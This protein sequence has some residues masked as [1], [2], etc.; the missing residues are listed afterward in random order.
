MWFSSII[1]R[2]YHIQTSHAK[3]IFCH[4]WKSL[5]ITCTTYFLSHVNIRCNHM[6]TSHAKNHTQN[7]STITCEC[8]LQSHVHITCAKSHA[9]STNNHMWMSPKSHV[10]IT[11]G[12]SHADPGLNHMWTSRVMV[13]CD[14]FYHH[15]RMLWDIIM[16][17]WPKRLSVTNDHDVTLSSL[18]NLDLHA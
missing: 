8:H 3:P 14:A 5:K 16:I 1:T 17:T 11:C 4:M 2:D 10:N 13:T 9:E 18:C 7:L 12:K 6:W 15:R